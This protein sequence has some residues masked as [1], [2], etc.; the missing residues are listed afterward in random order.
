MTEASASAPPPRMALSREALE[1]APGLLA[2][3]ESPPSR[4]PRAVLYAITSLLGLA[5]VWAAIGHLD[6]GASADGRLVPKTYLKV[7]QP[8][9]AGIVKEILVREGQRVSAGQVL[10]RLDAQ[11]AQADTAKLRSDLSRRSLQLR[12]IDAE[13]AG[14][15][16]RRQSDDSA[17]VYRQVEAQ[18]HERRQ[19]YLDSLGQVQ[20]QLHVAEREYDSGQ[21]VLRKL[22]ETNPILESQAQAYAGLG[23]EGY[24]PKVTVGDKQRA[25]IENQQDLAAQ[26]SKVQSLS[27]AVSQAGQQLRQTRSKYRSDLENERVDADSELS[28]LQQDWAKQTHHSNLLELRAPQA[29]IVKDLATHTVGTVVST[30]TVLLSIVPEREPLVA[31]VVIRNEDVGFVHPQQKVKIKLAAYP[32]QKY[33]LLDGE[34]LQVWPDA[35]EE[36]TSGAA[37]RSTDNGG[38]STAPIAG[39]KALVGLDRQ[40]LGEG[41]ESL[42][43]VAGMQIV[44][45]VREGRR[46]VLEYLVSPLQ[47]A[48]YDSGRE[49]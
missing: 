6:I 29:G 1:F 40:T 4:M 5:L 23:T 39:F 34:V 38:T 3:Q 37:S 20:Q 31:E 14:T 16:L 44:A 36:N 25:L 22:R 45:E 12:R 28:K 13:L 30:G 9:D 32:F 46:T 33:G 19:A 41:A 8:A 15:P 43:L 11:D 48:L 17:D 27:A 24:V 35:G 7:V 26:E 18:F 2:L 21:A 47:G 49:R 42:R 10:L